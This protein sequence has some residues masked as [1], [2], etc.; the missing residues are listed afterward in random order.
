MIEFIEEAHI[1]LLNGV[2]TPCVSDILRFIFPN[3][4]KGVDKRVLTKKAEYGSVV[5][6]AIECLEQNLDMPELNYIQEAS[7]D[8][9][10]KIKEDNNIKVISQEQKIHYENKYCGT[11]DMEATIQ[12]EHSLVDIKTTAELDKEYLSWQLSFY[13]LAIG[14]RFKKLYCLWLPKKNLGELVEIQRKTKKELLKVLE[15]YG[16]FYKQSR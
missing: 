9:Y 13:E 3:K 10:K 5:H 16:N 15:D 14:K 12:G 6:K 2:I 4:Y 7:L 11:Y 1:Y 8:Q